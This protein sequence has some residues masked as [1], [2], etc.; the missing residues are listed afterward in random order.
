MDDINSTQ[1]DCSNEYT[2]RVSKATSVLA[3]RSN[4]VLP[5]DAFSQVYENSDLLPLAELTAVCKQRIAS[6]SSSDLRLVGHADCKM[7][8]QTKLYPWMLKSQNLSEFSLFILA[9]VF[10]S[11]FSY[12]ET[13]VCT[14]IFY[15]SSR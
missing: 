1:A 6:D 11:C 9:F 13:A 4:D 3:L 10:T 12:K 15:F 14:L 5:S 2:S 7:P 8:T